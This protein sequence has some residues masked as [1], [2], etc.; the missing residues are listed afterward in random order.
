MKKRASLAAAFAASLFL[1]SVSACIAADE[2]RASE[3]RLLGSADEAAQFAAYQPFTR[4]I[5]SSGTV[6]VVDGKTNTVKS[7]LPVTG[8]YIAVNP[9]T[10]KVYVGGQDSSLTVLD[11]K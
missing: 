6:S 4:E 7:V 3:E 2:A 8:L 5:T 10:E 9:A 11:E 1:G